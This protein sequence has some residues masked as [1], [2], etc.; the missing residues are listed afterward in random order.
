MPDAGSR[1]QPRSCSPHQR[2]TTPRC[3]ATG[4]S[5][6]TPYG[7]SPKGSLALVLH[8]LEEWPPAA[9]AERLGIG[10]QVPE[11]LL[12]RARASLRRE[13]ERLDSPRRGHVLVPLW[14]ALVGRV[15]RRRQRA[16]AIWDGLVVHFQ[17]SAGL[18]D[19]ATV[20]FAAIAVTV[21]VGSTSEAFAYAPAPV[22]SETSVMAPDAEDEA[23]PPS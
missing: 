12:Y 11:Q 16:G 2:T 8:Y 4:R 10:R 13:Y 17:G 5:S 23:R 14:A 6:S 22:A 18:A 1:C 7:S 20:A 3:T 19:A 21:S 15:E 9:L